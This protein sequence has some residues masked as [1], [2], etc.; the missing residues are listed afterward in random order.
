M[1]KTLKNRTIFCRDNLEILRGLDDETVNL[2]YLD[3]PFN[4]KKVFTAPIGS[5]ASGASFED[6]FKK[7]DVKKEWLGL[8]ADLYPKLYE[9]ISGVANIGHASNRNY[10][11]YMAIRLIEM[12]RVLH[13]TGSLYLHCDQTMS[14]YL[15]ILL[16]CIFGENNFRNE[17][18]W[19]YG[20]GGASKKHWARKHDTVYFYSKTNV[21]TF[22]VDLIR[23]EYKWKGGQKRA[24]G[25]ERDLKQGKLPDDV[26]QLNGLMPWAKEH[27]GYPT[28]KPL[29]LIRRFIEASSQENDLVLDPFCGC[30][31]T[32]V[33]A[34]KLKR[35]WVGIDISKKAF[36]IVKKRL[37]KEIERNEIS[38]DP[39]LF[40]EK[41][42]I[43]RDDIPERTD[44]PK[45]KRLTENKH[46][47]F[48]KQEGKCFGCHVLFHYRNLTIDHI[49]PKT[50]GG[51][52]DIRNLQLLCGSC[53]SLKADKDM[54]YLKLKLKKLKII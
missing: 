27:V 48:G 4:K 20:G 25:S 31:T 29:T 22:N 34:E 53:N 37:G 9:Y 38:G 21:W 26:I 43:Y 44:T 36:D 23:E 50:K 19:W 46:L 42:V 7:K 24:D 51:G 18:I 32:C 47:L 3:P 17:I 52:D 15:K 49:V 45:E 6:Y 11:C 10:L 1:Q 30:A 2:I 41:E 35:K 5:T 28:Q 16:D 12:H 13:E 39:A 54:A 40:F 8:I 33:M 14:H